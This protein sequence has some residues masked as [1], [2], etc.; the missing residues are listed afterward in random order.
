MGCLRDMWNETADTIKPLFHRVVGG[1]HER[2]L[3][4]ESNTSR[5]T[6]KR[7]FFTGLVSVILSDSLISSFNRGYRLECT[8]IANSY[9]ISLHPP[10]SILR[11]LTQLCQVQC[12]ME[13]LHEYER[14]TAP[15]CNPCS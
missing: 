12:L 15:S 7:G 4:L 6:E 13:L 9:S 2:Y 14:N 5:R 11:S 1:R 3:C 10:I 8:P